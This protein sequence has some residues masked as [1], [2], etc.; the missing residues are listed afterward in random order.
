MFHRKL[1]NTTKP[2][3]L[4]IPWRENKIDIVGGGSNE[5]WMISL[6]LRQGYHQLVAKK[7]DR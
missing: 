2:F 7:P 1:N 6:D 4:P 5:I 3:T